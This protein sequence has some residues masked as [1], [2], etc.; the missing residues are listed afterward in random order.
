MPPTEVN[1]LRFYINFLLIFF[2]HIIRRFFVFSDPDSASR[3]LAPFRR[4]GPDDVGVFSAGGSFPFPVERAEY[5]EG[6]VGKC[7]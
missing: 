6:A 4:P 5:G 7:P 1:V 3:L 2:S